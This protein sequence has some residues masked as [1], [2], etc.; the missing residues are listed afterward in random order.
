MYSMPA[1]SYEIIVIIVLVQD[2]CVSKS[3][4]SGKIVLLLAAY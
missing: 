3:P 2:A 4:S 1:I